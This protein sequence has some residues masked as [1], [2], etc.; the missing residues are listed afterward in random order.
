MLH[1]FV[2][3]LLCRGWLAL[4]AL[5]LMVAPSVAQ[6]LA[7]HVYTLADGLPQSTIYALAQ[8]ADGRLWAGTQS[9]ACWFDG[10]RFQTID[11]H[12]GLPDNHVT[13][14]LPAPGGMW[15]G[16]EY[17]DVSGVD[18][19]GRVRQLGPQGWRAQAPVRTL[20][21][22]PGGS[23][24]V[25]TFGDG[26]YRLLLTDKAAS[27]AKAPHWNRAR[28]L[29]ADT[30]YQLA[31][32]PGGQLWAATAA[33]LTVLDEA[34]GQ[35]ETAAGL[36]AALRQQRVYSLFRQAD[37]LYWLGLRT[38]L[39]RLSRPNAA[40]PWRLRLIGSPAQ[41]LCAGAV[42]RVLADRR[43]VV[44]TLSAA[45]VSRYEPGTGR[46]TCFALPDLLTDQTA[47]LE[48]REGSLWVGLADG[49]LQH[50]ADERFALFGATEGLAN[51]DA[52]GLLDMGHGLLWVGTRDG[53][54][55]LRPEA[56][57]GQRFRPGHRRPGGDAAN[58]IRPLLR[59]SKGRVWVG[60]RGGGAAVYYPESGRW[61]ELGHGGVAGQ[62]IRAFAEDRLG[63]MWVLTAG[64]G[65][66]VINDPAQPAHRR[67]D[68][69]TGLGTN[70]L[71]TGFRDRAGTLWLGTDDHG[72]VRVDVQPGGPDFLRR[73][74][75]RRDRLSIGSITEDA[76][77]QLWLGS[78]G[79]G[80]LRFDGR[81]LHPLGPKTGLQSNN[82]YFVRADAEGKLWLGT[83]LGL[84][85]FDPATGRTVSF[86]PREGFLGQETNQNA[87][88][89]EP[90]G[91]MWV[92]TVNG[93]M[94]YEPARAR[95]NAAVPR[96]L[97]TGLRVLGQDTAL[98]A[99]FSLPPALNQL[100]FDFVGVSLTNPAKVRYQYRLAGF[101]EQWSRPAAAT[102]ATYT[103]LPPGDYTFEVKAANNDGVWNPAPTRLSFRIR[104]PWWRTWWA[105][106]LYA[107]LLGAAFYA[108]RRFTQR[109]ERNRA[110]QQLEYQ[111]LAHLQE[112]DRVKSE[113][114]TH[115]SHEL[116]T[117]LTLILGPAEELAH[118]E[119]LPATVRG[120]GSRV[121]HNAR[122]LLH[123]INQLLDLSRLE[124][125]ALTLHLR[126]ADVAA[127]ARGWAAAFQDLAQLRGVGLHLA[128]PAGPVPLTYD[129]VRLEEVVSNLL[130]NALRFTPA[131]G[132]VTLAVREEA[133][134]AAAPDG[135][136]L[137]SVQDTGVGIAP[138][139]LPRLFDRF[140]QVP[141]GGPEAVGSGVGLALV[142][143][144]TERHGGAVQVLSTP[145]AG[146]TFVVRLPRLPAGAEAA[147]PAPAAETAPLESSLPPLEELFTTEATATT[148]GDELVLVVEDSTE[149]RD[150]IVA[151]LR[152]EGYRVLGAPD[153]PGGLALAQ[154][155]VPSLVVSDVM[156]PGF[157]GYELCLRLKTGVATSH[158]PVVL[159]TARA[160]A[161]DR[162]QGLETGA[163]A[164][165]PKP[166]DPRELRAQV[167]N[168][169]AL[170]RRTQAQLLPPTTEIPADEPQQP[171]AAPPPAGT[172]MA[173]AVFEAYAAAVAALPSLDQTFLSRVE[174][175]VERHL[176]NGEF[177]VEQLADEV[178]LSRAQLHRKLKA[179]TG[180][181][182]SDFI[183]GLRLR[184]AHVLLAARAGTV[185]EVAYQVGFNSPAHFS[186]SFSRQFGY[187]PSE[188]PT[189]S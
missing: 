121:L 63:R 169:L 188:V 138:E 13:A 118:D 146:S 186:T 57:A 116:R 19:Q 41:P 2:F 175:A 43:G 72:L 98:T 29:A 73:A 99:G 3:R 7:T 91:R 10:H 55:E 69:T 11:T 95:R 181:A 39:G 125:G 159:L 149:V 67:Y 150:Y 130:A 145:G 58:F 32:G 71:W 22:A 158:I 147:E 25:G 131:G 76:R 93:V 50:A 164:Y 174:Q 77:G 85:R 60:S 28:G 61:L 142:K 84:D 168:L 104:P 94:R 86:G 179:L 129:A 110:R 9:G 20:Q 15:L 26:L 136:V 171:A 66:T 113:F 166:F 36:P 182:P 153:G 46:V 128:L 161:A 74:D 47:L 89:L 176:D 173:P 42:E 38:G 119:A 79:E 80:L 185:S 12:Y 177:S 122:K 48:D 78:I 114:F 154:D 70:A 23:L 133:P 18:A 33:G 106:G 27:G 35:V 49:L 163:D 139:A 112:M 65:A 53:L 127:A 81:R 111:A 30:I 88:L 162:L 172:Q 40:S 24:W 34:T 165:L 132:H 120:Q 105:Y 92:G 183:R 31:P 97:F 143:E 189:L 107:L 126:P 117:P 184:R 151:T 101:D 123:L 68:A 178:A 180:Q 135:A 51:P 102:S 155:A 45:G 100:T 134:T 137:L 87:V 187:A 167:R 8:D 5:L 108:V 109:R 37:T 96:T 54:W 17:G 62:N 157:D 90:D 6:T 82:P 75:G 59:D 4:P 148:E 16:H 64:A 170:R 156:M 152:A 140:Y 14:L 44:W 141:T 160:T 103:N 1:R 115:I 124:A 56:P 52:Q 21:S 83:N 144:L